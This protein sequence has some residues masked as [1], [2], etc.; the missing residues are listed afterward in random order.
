MTKT[1]EDILTGRRDRGA[2]PA[3]LKG[4]LNVKLKINK[5]KI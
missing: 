1:K 5:K 4:T 2:G 3:Q